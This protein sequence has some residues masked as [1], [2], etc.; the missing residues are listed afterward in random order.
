LRSGESLLS[1]ISSIFLSAELP[2]NMDPAIEARRSHFV[3]FNIAMIVIQTVAVTLRFFARYANRSSRESMFWWDDY[4]VLIALPVSISVNWIDISMVS[5]GFGQHIE[6]IPPSNSPRLFII[7]YASEFTFNIGSALAKASALFFYQRVFTTK[8]SPTLKWAMWTTQILNLLWVIGSCLGI[9]FSCNPVEKGW[10]P[11]LPGHCTRS[12]NWLGSAIPSVIID[13]IILV[14]PLPR[15]WKLNINMARKIVLVVTFILGYS[16]VVISLGRLITL[17]KNVEDI[18]TDITYVALPVFYWY[19]VEIPLT[20]V[21]VC[22][23][24]IASYFRIV[25]DSKGR[26]YVRD[27]YGSLSVTRSRQGASQGS[28]L[29]GSG[30]GKRDDRLQQSQDSDH[31]LNHWSHDDTKYDAYCVKGSPHSR[32]S[33]IGS[34]RNDTVDTAIASL[35][36]VHIRNDTRVYSE[37]V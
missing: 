7:L 19:D 1:H 8:H 29:Y 20:I 27:H 36:Q 31:Q 15:L 9:V 10:D 22:L 12:R 5:L 4:I 25:W 35:N 18:E 37:H 17:I 23:I 34:A 30:T 3:G 21:S 16:I 32:G 24:I 2:F 14:L 6:D 33:D 13:V 11:V 28:K 26:Q